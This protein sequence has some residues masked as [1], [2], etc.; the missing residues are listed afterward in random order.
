MDGRWSVGGST[1]VLHLLVPCSVY[2]WFAHDPGLMASVSRVEYTPLERS[3]WTAPPPE[4]RAS[5]RS[6]PVLGVG[7]RVLNV[8][9]SYAGQCRLLHRCEPRM[10]SKRCLVG[11]SASRTAAKLLPCRSMSWCGPCRLLRF[12]GCGWMIKAI[13]PVG[14]S[15]NLQ[16]C[17]PRAG[18]SREYGNACR[19]LLSPRTIYKHTAQELGRGESMESQRKPPPASPGS[20]ACCRPARPAIISLKS[21]VE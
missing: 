20:A 8:R 2:L 4:E 12:S 9:L 1:S 3:S 21:R 19:N 6:L 13:R 7:A 11:C 17:R 10:L 5:V 15:R 14:G 16:S 18:S